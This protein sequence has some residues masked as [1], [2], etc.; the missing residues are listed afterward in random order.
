M[1]DT[2]PLPVSGGSYIRDPETGALTLADMTQA[3]VVSEVA[4]VEL[5][6]PAK[7]AVK[8]AVKPASKPA[9]QED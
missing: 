5:T 6:E 8:G 9:S 7:P 4:P 1:S 3:T 2:A